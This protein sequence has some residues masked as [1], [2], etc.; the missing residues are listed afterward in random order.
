MEIDGIIK[1]LKEDADRYMYAV[2]EY[3]YIENELVNQGKIQANQ[4][5]KNGLALPEY[6][7]K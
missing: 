1:Q 2:K 5:P 4:P 6:D 7:D 3:N